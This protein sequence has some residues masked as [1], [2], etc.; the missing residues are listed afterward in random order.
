PVFSSDGEKLLFV[1]SS[2]AGVPEQLMVAQCL[3]GESTRIV[4]QHARILGPP[5]WSIDG[6][7]VIF[8]SDFGSHP[9][10]WRVPVKGND[11]PAQINDSG[12]Y[13]SISRQGYR[14]AYQRISHSLNVWEL[15]LAPAG[16][17]RKEQ[18]VLVSS[19][20]ETDQ[21]PGPQISPDGK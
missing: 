18:H 20:S 10:L 14:L 16:E 4:S 6:Q 2:E 3:T 19:T 7:S 11:A 21:G 15:D 8:A 1:R 13:P 5:Q 17:P 12:W 9:G